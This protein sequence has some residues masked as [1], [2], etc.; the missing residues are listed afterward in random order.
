[1]H[2]ARRP[3]AAAAFREERAHE[4]PLNVYGYSKFLFDQI[5]RRACSPAPTRRSSASAISTSM[6]RANRTRGAWPR[7]PF[8]H[9]NQFRAEGKVRLFEGCAATATA[10]SG[11]ISSM[12]ATWS[13]S[14][15]IFSKPAPPASST[16]APDAR[17][18]ST[19]WPPPPSMPAARWKA[20]RRCPGRTGGAGVHR[21]RPV[22][23]RLK[24]KYQSFTEADLSRLRKLPATELP[25]ASV[26]EGVAQYVEM[27]VPDHVKTLEITSAD[28]P[29]VR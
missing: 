11:A 7:W 10:S 12:S 1:M 16:S 14:I 24:G 29:L 15:W 27:A 5:V 28:T 26:E 20:S 9:Y 4:A 23:R 2:R 6:V 22:S 13:R 3:T 18:A 19:N 8:H 25:F 17:R 21:V